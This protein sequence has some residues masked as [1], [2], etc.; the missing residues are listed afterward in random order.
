VHLRVRTFLPD[1]LWPSSLS[2]T[3]L[4]ACRA[5][6][7]PETISIFVVHGLRGG[8]TK[9]WQHPESGVIWFQHL[10]PDYI[11]EETKTDSARIWT[12][13]YTAD[14]TFQASTVR[15]LSHALLNWVKEARKGQE[16]W[17]PWFCDGGLD[18]S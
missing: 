6:G 5:R 9:S 10:L 13:G 7:D 18:G 8:A 15:G 12:F 17:H 1:F 14:L 2:P 4:S 3:G 11:R 16:V